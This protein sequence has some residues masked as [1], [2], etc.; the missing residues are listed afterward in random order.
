MNALQGDHCD[1]RLMAP[2]IMVLGHRIPKL[3]SC[4]SP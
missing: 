1:L 3:F 4:L 2:Y